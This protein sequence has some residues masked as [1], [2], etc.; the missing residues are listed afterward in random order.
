MD[1]R[2]LRVAR[3]VC[4][5]CGG[6]LFVRISFDLLGTRC[7]SCAAS[8]I[9]MAIGK[10]LKDRVPGFAD[11][12]LCELSSQGPF[13]A[14]LSRAVECGSGTLTCS[15]YYDGVPPGAFANGVQCQDVQHLTYAD[16][17]FDVCTSTEVFEHVPDDQRGF[18]ELHRVLAQG[19]HLLLTVPL[20][21][22]DVTAERAVLE[23]GAIRHLLPATYHD[24]QI[25]GAGKVLVYRDY[26]RD[27]T[28]RLG[29]AGFA[30][31]EIVEVPDPAGRSAI[32]QVVTARR[33]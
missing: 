5:L 30:A 11:L 12:R 19:G 22:T 14:S 21:D 32:A 27:I 1:W 7:V 33:P 26:G 31:P 23:D 13:F 3:G 9:S 24:D 28:Q 10:V 6:K 18:A 4:P 2:A 15:E 17:S 25:R 16:A 29:E 20:S 8:P